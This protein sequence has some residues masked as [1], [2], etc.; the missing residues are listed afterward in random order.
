MFQN[1]ETRI[2]RYISKKKQAMYWLNFYFEIFNEIQAE[3]F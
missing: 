1:V 3:Y 2:N